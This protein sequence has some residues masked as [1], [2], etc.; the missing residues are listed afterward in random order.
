MPPIKRRTW[1][2]SDELTKKIPKGME[3]NPLMTEAYKLLQEKKGFTAIAGILRRSSHYIWVTFLIGQDYVS[4]MVNLEP[5]KWLVDV[6]DIVHKATHPGHKPRHYH[7][8][9]LETV[10][11]LAWLLKR[12]G[13]DMKVTIATPILHHKTLYLINEENIQHA[14]EQEVSIYKKDF[15]RCPI[16]LEY[17]PVGTGTDNNSAFWI[18]RTQDKL[19]DA[20]KIFSLPIP[21]NSKRVRRAYM[22]SKRRFA[23]ARAKEGHKTRRKQR[24]SLKSNTKRASLRKE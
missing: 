6:T 20:G 8:T 4:L 3:L 7:K 21:R 22:E 19:W 15:N 23:S 1:K 2:K 13:Y 17:Y 18:D 5:Y 14:I 12:N 24:A 10:R 9:R 16:N 11:R